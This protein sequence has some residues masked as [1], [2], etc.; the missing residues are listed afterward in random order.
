MALFQFPACLL[1]MTR[2]SKATVLEIILR[3]LLQLQPLPRHSKSFVHSNNGSRL[4]PA[5][6]NR[7]VTTKIA[8]RRRRWLQP[9]QHRHLGARLWNC[10]R[11]EHINIDP[12]EHH[13]GFHIPSCSRDQVMI[14]V[15][16]DQ[17]EVMPY[18]PACRAPDLDLHERERFRPLVFKF[19]ERPVVPVHS[20]ERLGDPDGDCCCAQDRPLCYE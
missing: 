9:R 8:T 2:C 12:A 19:A 6:V 5:M 17:V 13:I 10:N 4:S 11:A 18:R 1:Q 7:T 3:L 15:I 20:S 14:V 16:A